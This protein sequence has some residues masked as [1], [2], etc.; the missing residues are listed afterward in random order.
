MMETSGKYDIL[1]GD[2][3]RNY[4]AKNYD[5]PMIQN[6]KLW[7]TSKDDNSHCL[8]SARWFWLWMRYL[9]TS[10]FLQLYFGNSMMMM[11][12]MMIAM[13]TLTRGFN[14]TSTMVK[15][16]PGHNFSSSEMTKRVCIKANSDF[17]EPTRWAFDVSSGISARLTSLSYCKLSFLMQ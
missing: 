10:E 2:E 16:W 11:M 3:D 8:C 5:Q 9:P 1:G 13:E 17:L 15:V 4:P 7:L 14:H 12:M 6:P